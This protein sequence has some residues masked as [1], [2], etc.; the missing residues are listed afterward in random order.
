MA[1]ETNLM[2]LEQLADVETLKG[3]FEAFDRQ[4]DILHLLDQSMKAEGV[5]IFIGHESGYDLLDS[6]S[7]V[8][9]PYYDRGRYDRGARGDRPDAHGLRAGDP[10]RRRDGEAARP[11][12]EV[13]PLGPICKRNASNRSAAVRPRGGYVM[14]R[15]GYRNGATGGAAAAEA[16]RFRRRGS[17]SSWRPARGRGELEQVHAVRPRSSTTSASARAREVE[18]ARKFGAERL[19]QAILPV[20][21]SLEAGI[22][23]SGGADQAALIEGQ[24]AT[25]RLLD[26]AFA[27]DRHPRDR[28]ARRAVRSQQARGAEHVAG[29]ACASRTPSSRS[30]RRATSSTTGCCAP[31]RSSWRRTAD[32]PA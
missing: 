23:A 27:S 25:L 1:G 32:G 3:L 12:L 8:A 20:R 30:S 24:Q 31:P 21:D 5:Q 17:R 11:R 14:S 6:C 26:D 10:D 28:P 29:A 19:A 15:R 4:R 22:A 16:R 18:A 13:G 2:G 9:A 7:I